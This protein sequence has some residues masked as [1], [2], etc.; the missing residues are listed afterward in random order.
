MT[1]AELFSAYY[2]LAMM[3]AGRL[4][5]SGYK[6]QYEI[7]HVYFM[8]IILPFPQGNLTHTSFPVRF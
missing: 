7:D 1:N 5:I 2:T 8:G 4:E 6:L 3:H